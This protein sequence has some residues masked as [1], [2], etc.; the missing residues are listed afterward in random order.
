MGPQGLARSPEALRVFP[1]S[2]KG[3]PSKS[4]W[5]MVKAHCLCWMARNPVCVTIAVS[6]SNASQFGRM[7]ARSVARHWW[8]LS[9]RLRR[10]TRSEVKSVMA[11]SPVTRTLPLRRS[12][13]STACGPRGCWH[14]PHHRRRNNASTRNRKLIRTR[15]I[16]LSIDLGDI[17]SNTATVQ[18]RKFFCKIA[19]SILYHF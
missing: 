11:R 8:S 9:R 6:A 3:N 15:Y 16:H 10:E 4:R 13:S 18:R 17:S 19:H 5:E 12:K 14:L 7:F 1:L 2:I